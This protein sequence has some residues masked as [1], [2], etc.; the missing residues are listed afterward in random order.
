LRLLSSYENLAIALFDRPARD[1]AQ[2]RGAQGFPRA[3]VEAGVMPGTPDRVVDREPVDERAL[4]VCA[5][6]PDR[7]YLGPAPQQQNLLTA[8]MAAELATI[9]KLG[10]GNPSREIGA[11][12]LGV[13]LSHRRLPQ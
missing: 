7:K 11:A 3:Q 6:S 2:S 9:G 5:T 4:V 8:N 12:W 10:E 1:R 13:I